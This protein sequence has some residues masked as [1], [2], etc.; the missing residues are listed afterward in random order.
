VEIP[1]GD[2]VSNTGVEEEKFFLERE[3]D[4]RPRI[5]KRWVV[6][7][8]NCARS[9]RGHGQGQ[10]PGT[11]GALTIRQWEGSA[12]RNNQPRWQ[13][14]HNRHI[15]PQFRAGSLGQPEKGWPFFC[16]RMPL[17]I[18]FTPRKNTDQIQEAG[19]SAINGILLILLERLS[20]FRSSSLPQELQMRC[21]LTFA[22]GCIARAARIVEARIDD[23]TGNRTHC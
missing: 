14:L 18:S 16:R 22:A 17:L 8:C 1:V 5:G 21:G 13:A 6:V 10:N 2:G 19:K 11:D 15:L 4:Y 9:G 7:P 12:R 23:A 3:E 20:W